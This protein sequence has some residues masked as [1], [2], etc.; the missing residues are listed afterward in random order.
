MRINIQR[1]LFLVLSVWNKYRQTIFNTNTLTEAINAY[2][3]ARSRSDKK[4]YKY[5]NDTNFGGLRGNL[6]TLL[7]WK[8]FVR[9]GSRIVSSYALGFDQ[10][11]LN[12]ID[13]GEISLDYKNEA[14]ATQNPRLAELLRREGWLRNLRETQA[15]IKIFLER[16]LDFPL[17]RDNANFPKE[18]VLV[19]NND[20]MFLRALV[21][22]FVGSKNNILQ[23]SLL[24]FWEG[25]KLNQ[26]NIHP[27]IV[28]PTKDDA[29][30]GFYA[31]S[32]ESLQDK[33]P[34]L[35]NINLETKKCFGQDKNEYKLIP[36]KEALSSFSDK[37][38]NIEWRSAYRWKNLQEYYCEQEVPDSYKKEDEFSVFLSQYLH[39]NKQFQ[40]DGKNIQDVTVISS[41]GP[42]VKLTFS[43]GTVQNLE[44]EHEWASYLK[45]G[46]HQNNAFKGCWIYAN[47]EFKFENIRKIFGPY[48]EKYGNNIPKVFLATNDKKKKAFYIDWD[49]LTCTEL[50]VSELS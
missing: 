25:K 11:I 2:E 3:T 43:G 50:K 47:E 30:H 1:I 36:L 28:L 4:D 44:L 22:N 20:V 34:I 24:P 39:W 41:G 16:H 9:R 37:S 5:G 12:A 38:E 46:H 13:K 23:Y 42:D 15:H 26:F 45:H 29:W 49:S 31:I 21:N 32:F 27:L 40:I 35:L 33:K 8:C 19:S 6:S 18:A 10:R 48:I 17:S 14:C 7:T